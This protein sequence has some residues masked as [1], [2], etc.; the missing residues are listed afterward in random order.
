MKKKLF[1]LILLVNTQANA[2]T[3]QLTI[4]NHF[5]SELKFIVGKNPD[6]LPDLIPT[7]TLAPQE[8][9]QTKVVDIQK[10]AYIRS[11]DKKNNYTFWGVNVENNQIKIRGYQSK[12]I[13]YSWT[14]DSVTFCTPDEYKKKNAC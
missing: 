7:F 2:A 9:I 8:Q 1:L 14:N 5:N 6:V 4:T 10:E 3:N 13:A 11:E 12:G